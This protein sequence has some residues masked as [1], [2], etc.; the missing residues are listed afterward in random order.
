MAYGLNQLLAALSDCV[1]PSPA[2]EQVV[3]NR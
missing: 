1:V 2:E 3:C